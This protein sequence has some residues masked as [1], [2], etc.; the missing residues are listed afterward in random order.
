MT[1]TASTLKKSWTVEAAKER[2]NSLLRLRCAIDTI[3]L[4]TDV[5]IFAPITIG[6]A[7]P[8][9]STPPPTIPTTIDVVEEEL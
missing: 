4:V 1:I 7:L 6:I 5:Q 3:V 2:R 8:T 9:V